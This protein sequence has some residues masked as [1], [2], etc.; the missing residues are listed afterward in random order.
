MGILYDGLD[1][2]GIANV[3][4]VIIL[5]TII[6]RGIMMPFNIRQQRSTKLTN[7][8]QPEISAIQAKYQGARDQYSMQAMQ[9]ETKAVYKKYGISQT[10][11]CVQ[12]LIQYPFL[13]AMYGA[14]R[15]IPDAITKIGDTLRPVA[16][17]ISTASSEI[18]ESVAEISS[19]LVGTDT[20]TVIDAL[21]SL[22]TKNWDA[23]AALFSGTDASAITSYHDQMVSLTSFLGC[24]LSQTPWNLMRGGGIGIIA[25]IIPIVAGAAQWLTFKLSQTSASEKSNDQMAATSRSMGMIMPLFTVFLCFTLN[26]GLGLYWGISSVLQ[27]VVQILINR[28]YRKVDME[29]YVKENMARA[30]EKEKKKRE[31]KGVSGETI[32]SAASI[33]TKNIQAGGQ[34]AQQRPRSISEI[35]NMNVNDTSA[36]SSKPPAGSLAEKAGMVNEYNENHPEDATARR[37]YKK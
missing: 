14:L 25:V 1:A 6:I 12:S 9:A 33:N 7:I 10:G 31:K 8:I 37:K 23:L 21:F 24:D 3:G 20:D 35:A 22:T 15:N 18:Q 17:I 29:E 2:I 16:D 19:S 34:P 32:S 36:K 28:H 26:A 30:A 5:F 4:L 11:G 13:I 27:V